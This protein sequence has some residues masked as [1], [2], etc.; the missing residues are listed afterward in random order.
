MGFLQ[1]LWMMV[2]VS[3]LAGCANGPDGGFFAQPEW[4]S[5]LER[6]P[7]DLGFEPAVTPWE[8]NRS[9]EAHLNSCAS[10]E[11]ATEDWA[12]VHDLMNPEESDDLSINI[13][14]R[15]NQNNT[16]TGLVQRWGFQDDS[17]AGTDYQLTLQDINGCWQ[18]TRVETRHY[19]RRGRAERNLCL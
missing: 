8:R 19:C 3:L 15:R 4:E 1:R 14:T 10:F 7:A 16:A 12:G 17:L 2:L 5:Y 13:R 11:K 6:V 18:P 9:L